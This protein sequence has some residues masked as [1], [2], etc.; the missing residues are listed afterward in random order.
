MRRRRSLLGKSEMVCAPIAPNRRIRTCN[1]RNRV[2]GVEEIAK[3]TLSSVESAA[4]LS[5]ASAILIAHNHPGGTPNPST[6]DHAFTQRIVEAGNLLGIP[7]RDHVI[8]AAGEDC[9]SFRQNEPS[10]AFNGARAKK[11]RRK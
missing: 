2:I 8:L 10:Y 7:V 4:I 3:G 6:A 9:F 1:S 5:N 11:K